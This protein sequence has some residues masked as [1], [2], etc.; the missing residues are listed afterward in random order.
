M[1][2]V[3]KEVSD[4]INVGDMV[5]DGHY[6]RGIVLE[7]HPVDP[8]G[9]SHMKRSGFVLVHF[10]NM[11]HFAKTQGNI[12]LVGRDQLKALKVVSSATQ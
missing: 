1:R 2:H 8:S 7:A 12:R 3:S 11:V 4:M 9:S 5:R 10:P 6:G